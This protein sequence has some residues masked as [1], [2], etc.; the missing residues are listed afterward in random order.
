M[1]RGC[2]PHLSWRFRRD[3]QW[4]EVGVQGDRHVDDASLARQWALAGAGI[5]LKSPL[6]QIQDMAEG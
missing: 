6:E 3:G 5:L 2:I 1:Q 4:V